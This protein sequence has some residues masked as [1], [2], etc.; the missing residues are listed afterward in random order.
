MVT[1]YVFP[2]DNDVE[3]KNFENVVN[4]VGPVVNEAVLVKDRN[5]SEMAKC[6]ETEWFGYIFTDEYIPMPLCM[7]LPHFL[8][9][10]FE[11]VICMRRHDDRR[12]SRS[13][14]FFRNHVGIVDGTMLPEEGFRYNKIT[15]LDGFIENYGSFICK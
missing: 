2:A 14:R 8:I 13:P 9:S 11:I 1:L 3:G 15:A 4:S 7:A 12:I 6:C 5:I 10:E